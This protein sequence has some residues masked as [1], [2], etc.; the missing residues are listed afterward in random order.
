M[1]ISGQFSVTVAVIAAITFGWRPLFVVFTAPRIQFAA[2]ARWPAQPP[3]VLDLA[4]GKAQ[5]Q[6]AFVF[7]RSIFFARHAR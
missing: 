6:A 2:P 4:T 5:S 3:P 7:G 1:N